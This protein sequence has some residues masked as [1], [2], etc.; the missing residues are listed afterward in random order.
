MTREC[1]RR[2]TAR[3][4]RIGEYAKKMGVT[5]DFLKHYGEKGIL[6]A[7]QRDGGYRWYDFHQSPVILECMR[8]RN[9]GVT[10]R[11]MKPLVTELSGPEALARIDDGMEMLRQRVLHDSAVIEEH[12]RLKAWFEARRIGVPVPDADGAPAPDWEVRP[13]EPLVFLPHST[14]LTFLD[15]PKVPEILP[16]WVEWMPVVKSALGIRLPPGISGIPE[17]AEG[18]PS[19]WGLVARES[20]AVRLRIPVNEVVTRIPGGRAFIAHFADADPADA[21][22]PV[23]LRI[24]SVLDRLKLTGLTPAGE[25]FMVLRM[26]ARMQGGVDDSGTPLRHERYGSFIVPLASANGC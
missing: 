8:L 21:A 9:H 22:D 17:D 3:S 16:A 4:Y 12:E 25:M 14:G 15:D 1:G 2:R 26:H 10:V 6:D 24:R 7:D 18:L 13:I 19:R 23:A 11:E 5:P 20:D